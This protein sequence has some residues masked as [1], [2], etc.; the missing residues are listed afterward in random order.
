MSILGAWSERPSW[1][2]ELVGEG[3]ELYAIGNE[4]DLIKTEKARSFC[5]EQK[6]KGTFYSL[7]VSDLPYADSDIWIEVSKFLLY[8]ENFE[9]V[10]HLVSIFDEVFKQKFQDEIREILQFYNE[11]SRFTDIINL[12]NKIGS[13][14]D[15]G[16]YKFDWDTDFNQYLNDEL[17]RVEKIF[18]GLKC[19]AAFL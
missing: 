2:A 10:C 6:I 13:S 19:I 3:S 1:M 15:H 17:Q 4:S 14:N 11:Q 8:Q 16:N 9:E 18:Q 7:T 12:I 5:A